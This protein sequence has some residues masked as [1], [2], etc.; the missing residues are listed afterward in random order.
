MKEEVR[1]Q[2][3]CRGP[4]RAR[5]KGD[6]ESSSRE[7]GETGWEAGPCV[8]GCRRGGTG[9][10]RVPGPSERRSAVTLRSCLEVQ[11]GSHVADFAEGPAHRAPR[12]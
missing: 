5:G 4:F 11:S 8:S 6:P 10:R 7:P 2:G 3:L 12:A 9:R 1:V